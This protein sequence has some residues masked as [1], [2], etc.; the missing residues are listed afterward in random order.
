MRKTILNEW[1]LSWDW[2]E[3][4]KKPGKEVGELG[5]RKELSKQSKQAKAEAKSDVISKNLAQL[6][7]AIELTSASV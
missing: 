5:G 4:R 2:K 1:Y 3:G 6:Y 7:E